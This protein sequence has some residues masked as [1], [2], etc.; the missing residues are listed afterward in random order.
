LKK[1]KSLK[2]LFAQQASSKWK[3][4]PS[5]ERIEKAAAVLVRAMQKQREYEQVLERQQQES[6]GLDWR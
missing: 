5:Q 6:D 3:D 2:R 1:Q 4:E